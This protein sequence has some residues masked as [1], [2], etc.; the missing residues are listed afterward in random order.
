MCLRLIFSKPKIC[1]PKPPLQSMILEIFLIACGIGQLIYCW[2]VAAMISSLTEDFRKRYVKDM[3]LL[4]F[5][6]FWLFHGKILEQI[7]PIELVI[8]ARTFTWWFQ[9]RKHTFTF[10]TL[11]RERRDNFRIVKCNESERMFPYLGRRRYL[12]ATTAVLWRN[13]WDD[14]QTWKCS[15]AHDIA[16]VKCLSIEEN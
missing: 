16:V 4:I 15:A 10:I 14:M 8:L 11:T 1:I 3:T 13:V 5:V 9:I 7:A 6:K 12:W 2:L